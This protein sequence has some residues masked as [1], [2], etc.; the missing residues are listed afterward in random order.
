MLFVDTAAENSIFS[1]KTL[2]RFINYN[3]RFGG[4]CCLHLRHSL[5][6]GSFFGSP[7]CWRFQDPQIVVTTSHYVRQ[8]TVRTPH[9]GSPKCWRFQDPQ[10]VVTT[11]HSVRQATVR[12]PHFGSPKCWRFQDPQIVVTTSHYVRQATVRTPHFLVIAVY[13]EHH[14]KITG[15]NILCW[16]NTLFVRDLRSSSRVGV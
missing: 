7:K 1:H 9:F 3:W 6:S 14:I 5:L 11:S 4:A 13:R 16:H 10:I 15:S 12:T 2:C 8:A